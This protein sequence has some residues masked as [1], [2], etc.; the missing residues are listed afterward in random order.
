MMW[1]LWEQ[2]AWATRFRCDGRASRCVHSG[3]R[4]KPFPCC[5]QRA[6]TTC[7]SS[8]PRVPS[9]RSSTP[10]RHGGACRASP[11]IPCCS[12]HHQMASRVMHCSG[13]ICTRRPPGIFVSPPDSWMPSRAAVS[14]KTLLQRSR[15]FRSRWMRCRQHP[16]ARP[17][18]RRCVDPASDRAM[19]VRSVREDAARP[20]RVH[21]DSQML[22]LVRDTHAL[23]TGMERRVLPVRDDLLAQGGIRKHSRHTLPCSTSI[24]TAFTRIIL[25]GAC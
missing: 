24:R 20:R 23:E 12:V 3:V 10:S 7:S 17:C 22:E 8:G 11:P 16:L 4:P 5:G 21:V 14:S 15:L 6:T 9:T 19:A 1:M 25:R 18:L 2:A 13:N